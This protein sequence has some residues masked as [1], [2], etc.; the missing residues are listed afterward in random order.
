MNTKKAEIIISGAILAN[1]YRNWQNKKEQ[2][3]NAKSE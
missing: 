3:Q 1:I 2:N